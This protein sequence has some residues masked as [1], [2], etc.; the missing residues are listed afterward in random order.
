MCICLFQPTL[1]RAARAQSAE[2]CS[3]PFSHCTNN[4]LPGSNITCYFLM[5]FDEIEIMLSAKT[6]LTILEGNGTDKTEASQASCDIEESSKLIF[7]CVC[8]CVRACVCVV[9]FTKV[10]PPTKVSLSMMLV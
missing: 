3:I 10:F 8:A 4:V 5:R 1:K 6:T 2:N 9:S 7:V